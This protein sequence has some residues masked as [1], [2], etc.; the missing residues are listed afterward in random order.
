MVNSPEPARIAALAAADV[1]GAANVKTNLPPSMRCEDFAHMLSAKQGGYVWIGNGPGEGGC[2]LHS[3]RYD[4]NDDII[5]IG[6][7]YWA[8]LVRRCLPPAQA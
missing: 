4:F 2:L 1:V 6:V 5:G 7:S 8:A 3:N